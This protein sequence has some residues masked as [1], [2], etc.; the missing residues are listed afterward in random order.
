MIS[1]L[2][3]TISFLHT[4]FILFII[5]AP[6]TSSNYILLLHFITMP[7]LLFHWLLNND[8]CVL[9]LIERGLRQNVMEEYKEE[10]CFT[11]NLFGPVYKFVD[12]HNYFSKMIYLFVIFFWA[13]SFF[14]LNKKYRNKDITNWKDLF[15]L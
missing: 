1:I 15:I 10:D 9:T 12:N 6:F 3:N 11:C 14:N 4:L 2:S 5:V 13:I 8:T 7:F